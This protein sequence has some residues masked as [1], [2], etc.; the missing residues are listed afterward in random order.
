MAKAVTANKSRSL[1]EVLSQYRGLNDAAAIKHVMKLLQKA[2]CVDGTD[3]PKAALWASS[4]SEYE[5]SMKVLA[6]RLS[7]ECSGQPRHTLPS[8][9]ECI[10]R[11]NAPKLVSQLLTDPAETR[12][13]AICMA[14]VASRCF[15]S[16]DSADKERAVKAWRALLSEARKLYV[17]ARFDNGGF[18]GF[19]DEDQLLTSEQIN[20]GIDL[21]PIGSSERCLLKLLQ[22]S[23]P[24]FPDGYMVNS[25]LLNWG[26]IKIVKSSE[27]PRPEVW[28]GEAVEPSREKGLLIVGPDQIILVLAFDVSKQGPVA[29]KFTLSPGP[30]SEVRAY[31]SRMPESLS[32]LFPQV[33]GSATFHSQPY[34]G[35]TGRDA[36]NARLNRMLARVFGSMLTQTMFR[37]SL[38]HAH[39]QHIEAA[40]KAP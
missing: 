40:C 6:T 31:L 20:K 13:V 7:D 35:T 37:L 21:L 15:P 1:Q 11:P 38:V 12:R 28:A 8:F 4:L 2:P 5:S 3:S 26:H 14:S 9:F 18:G 34:V 19:F 39:K 32:I 30:A 22:A 16:L 36:F 33:K 10:L 27:A 29:S 17:K 25:P 23:V 24:H